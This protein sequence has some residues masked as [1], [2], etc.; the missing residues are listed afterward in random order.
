M[1]YLQFSLLFPKQEKE[2]Y[3]NGV[4]SVGGSQ[5]KIS[6]FFLIPSFDSFAVW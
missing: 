1:R 3:K 4:K 5:T 6:P 2:L